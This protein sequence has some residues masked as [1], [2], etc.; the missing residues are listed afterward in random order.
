MKCLTKVISNYFYLSVIFSFLSSSSIFSIYT[1]LI[2]N[3]VV[4][5][6]EYVICYAIDY[7]MCFIHLGS[8]GKENIAI[9]VEVLLYSSCY[10]L[11][12]THILHM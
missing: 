10:D 8:C 9:V 12:R 4:N 2:L 3:S 5:I 1:H 11:Q 7:V 6:R